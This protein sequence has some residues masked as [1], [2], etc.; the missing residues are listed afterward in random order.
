M[1]FKEA[2]TGVL[3]TR[4]RAA[5]PYN[6]GGRAKAPKK[7]SAFFSA[8]P[9]ATVATP[10]TDDVDVNEMNEEEGHALGGYRSSDN[11]FNFKTKLGK[12]TDTN[13]FLYAPRMGVP[14]AR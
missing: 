8:G 5:V 9:S 1:G 11:F 4:K 12:T 6:A 10:L 13:K 14:S 2:A 7:D 3:K